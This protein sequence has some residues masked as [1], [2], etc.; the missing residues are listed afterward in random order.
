MTPIEIFW[1]LAINWASSAVEGNFKNAFMKS[2]YLEQVTSIYNTTLDEYE[3]KYPFTQK[4][5]GK[6]PFYEAQTFYQECLKFRFYEELDAQKI[7]D[8]IKRDN[9]IITTSKEKIKE[10]L[11]ILNKGILANTELKSIF[12]AENY[13]QEIFN[14][15]QEILEFKKKL[16]QKIVI[17]TGN[18]DN[19][20]V[21]KNLEN[22][23]KLIISLEK[24]EINTTLKQKEKLKE[25]Q[26]K[27]AKEYEEPIWG[28][29][30]M[31]LKDTYIEQKFG[32]YRE[33]YLNKAISNET[34]ISTKN[35]LHLFINN[36]IIN[37]AI[38][39]TKEL[40]LKN[41]RLILLLGQPGQGKSSFC[42]RLMYDI[43]HIQ[44]LQ[45]QTTFRIN[46]RNITDTERLIAN[47]LDTLMDFLNKKTEIEISKELFRNSLLILDGLDELVIQERMGDGQEEEFLRKLCRDMENYPNIRII[48][49]SRHQVQ[50]E[51]FNNDFLILNFSLLT[52]EEEK[53][54]LQK[55]YQFYPQAF[56]TEDTLENFQKIPH[57]K[58]LCE[59][60]ILL[61]MLAQVHTKENPIDN[62][63]NRATI[64]NHLF[65]RIIERKW[66]KEGQIDILKG[67]TPEI[68][69]IFLQE[70]GFSIFQLDKEYIYK[71]E[72]QKMIT[73]HPELKKLNN[74]LSKDALK[75]LMTAFYVQ[76]TLKLENDNNSEDNS[77]YGI[78]FMHK[79]LQEF[80][81]AEKIWLEYK[82]IIN[83]NRESIKT[84]EQFLA[85]LHKCFY[86]QFLT[87]NIVKLL[88]EIIQNDKKE[89]KTELA[90]YITKFFS[91]CFEHD[92]LY[93]YNLKED[94]N[95][96][97]H[98]LNIFY[99]FWIIISSLEEE[100][101][102][103]ISKTKEKFCT[104][105]IY[106][107]S[108][109]S[110]CYLNL[111]SLNLSNSNLSGINLEY[112][113]LS[114]TNLSGTNLSGVNLRNANLSSANLSGTNLNGANLSETN[115]GGANLSGV[116]LEY[117]NLSDANLIKTN[118]SKANL[119]NANLIGINLI[120]ANLSNANLSNVNLIGANLSVANLSKAN[121]KNANLSKADLSG[122]I[123]Y[124]TD[125]NKVDLK[126]ANLNNSN[127]N[128]IN[129][130]NI[131]NITFEQLFKV[132][133]LK[134]CI[135][136]SFEL[137]A[138]LREKCPHLFL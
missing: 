35:S 75:G 120:G 101:N 28:E 86:K 74:L 77:N 17:L 68:M 58:E 10:F 83:I 26:I 113:N 80:L 95:P 48:I 135:G 72:I 66:T 1:G 60:P 59:Q 57:L 8:E 115:L 132:K 96:I 94:K 40:K 84:A 124:M 9:K 29:D 85:I 34:F 114:G 51:K 30:I 42:K 39:D 14:I 89:I 112:T 63:A 87:P 46:F 131:K 71:P 64:Y 38:P 105:L 88:I 106:L 76:E 52:F 67:I 117:A 45:Q 136:L 103:I 47:P 49:T 126:E 62:E 43:F 13:Q 65:T 134:N 123:L 98:I 81:A 61:Y 73:K 122:V 37:K 36:W 104:L 78:E 92:F 90:N 56:L 69:R 111:N 11:N 107:R 129:L 41:E 19:S 100:K 137:E 3:K 4:E 130:S 15:S 31:S 32:V 110:D 127:L 82:N 21:L 121:L 55:Y 53:A 23:K 118:L 33:C 24:S 79:S 93:D 16:E 99:G 70:I 25:Y 27:L 125:L 22:I 97:E 102:N 133:V 18:E 128:N 44:T 116:N 119:S 6:Y 20:I 7:Y 5:E 91:F 50:K 109:K 138:E 2:S 108:Y 54:W 12:L